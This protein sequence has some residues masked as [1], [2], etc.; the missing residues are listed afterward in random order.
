MG[1]ADESVEYDRANRLLLAAAERQ[2]VR[3]PPAEKVEQLRTLKSLQEGPLDRG[4]EFLARRQPALRQLDEDVR[5]AA[6]HESETSVELRRRILWDTFR[7]RIAFLVGTEAQDAPDSVLRT[8]TAVL[9]V[10]RYLG[11]AFGLPDPAE[12]DGDT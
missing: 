12:A 8:R 10:N 7:D 11:V 9:L 4:Y 3:Q 6:T 1:Q 2:P 5:N